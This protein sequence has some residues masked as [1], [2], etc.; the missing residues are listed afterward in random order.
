MNFFPRSKFFR[1]ILSNSTLASFS[2]LIK[3]DEPLA[4][5]IDLA[6][7][8]NFISAE[9]CFSRS[10]TCLSISIV[11]LVCSPKI[12]SLTSNMFLAVVN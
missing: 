8:A 2:S 9:N 1:A 10:F 11:V 4:E 6:S 5:A 3:S 12:F 7:L